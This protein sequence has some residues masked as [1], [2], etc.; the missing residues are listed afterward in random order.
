[1]LGGCNRKA[2]QFSEQPRP[3]R[4][5][6]TQ[7]Q[8]RDKVLEYCYK[9]PSGGNSGSPDAEE[10]I[11]QHLHYQASISPGAAQPHTPAYLRMKK[12]LKKKFPTQRRTTTNKEGIYSKPEV[13]K[14][15]DHKKERGKEQKSKEGE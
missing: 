4:T 14:A 8:D 9:E 15:K 6:S 13:N 5:G 12:E 1:M 2:F 7:I 10:Q 11:E 3:N